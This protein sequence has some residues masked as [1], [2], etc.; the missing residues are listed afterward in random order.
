MF[1][2]KI[3]DHVTLGDISRGPRI[4]IECDQINEFVDLLKSGAIAELVD[5]ESPSPDTRLDRMEKTLRE[6]GLEP[7]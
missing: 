7:A 6:Y 5:M 4:V 2:L 3:G 1:R